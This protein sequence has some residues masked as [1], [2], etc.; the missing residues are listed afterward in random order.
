MTFARKLKRSK[1]LPAWRDDLAASRA[2]KADRAYAESA[3]REARADMDRML[4][5][6]AKRR[7]ALIAEFGEAG[8]G[9]AN[10]V[11]GPWD[12]LWP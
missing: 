8:N 10:E 9:Y 11:T 7:R 4:K 2:M 1:P 3:G 6:R 12:G 5:R